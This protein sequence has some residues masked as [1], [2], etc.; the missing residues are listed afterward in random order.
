MAYEIINTF[1]PLNH[2]L[3][4]KRRRKAILSTII[5]GS[6]HHSLDEKI[7]LNIKRYSYDYVA[8]MIIKPEATT[9]GAM[10]II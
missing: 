1:T 6:R 5:I 10:T 3:L 2:F 9:N 4:E 8:S 7:Y